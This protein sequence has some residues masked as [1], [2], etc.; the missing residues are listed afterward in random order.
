MRDMLRL[1]V[2]FCVTGWLLIGVYATATS[3][4]VNDTA[5]TFS[6]MMWLSRS[7]IIAWFVLVVGGWTVWRG[8]WVW[9]MTLA[10]TLLPLYPNGLVPVGGTLIAIVAVW[11]VFRWWQQRRATE[12]TTA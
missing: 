6:G 5:D 11:G 3:M 1:V 2:V 7:A 9:P 8:Q 12:Y 4:T 10:I